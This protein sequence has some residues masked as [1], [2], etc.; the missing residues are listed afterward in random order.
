[1]SLVRRAADKIAGLV[2][3]CASAGSKEWALAIEGELVHIESDWRALAWALS[4]VRVL[5]DTQPGPLGTIAEL[6]AEVQRYADRR[7][8]AMNN[9]WLATN[10]PLFPFLVTALE[11]LFDIGTGRHVFN[12]TVLLMGLL[13]VVPWLYRR[14][15]EPNVPDRDDQGGL[16]RFYK[17]ELSA[18]T[19]TSMTFWMLVVGAY[20]TIVGFE[21]TSPHR[22]GSG[23][24][25][26]LLPVLILLP[27]LALLLARLRTMR[28]RL[29]QVDALLEANSD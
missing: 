21:L 4:G 11:S 17:D 23:L 5:F 2:V 27:V 20:V 16:I 15:R 28:R 26:L 12:H 29:A 13:L 18:V 22:W 9:G 24:R 3:R 19:R 7:R 10:L 8:N 1:M 14:T 25:L 6:D